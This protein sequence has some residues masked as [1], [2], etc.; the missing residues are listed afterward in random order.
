MEIPVNLV[1]NLPDDKGK[2]LVAMTT[3]ALG[4][5]WQE[6]LQE[7]LGNRITGQLSMSPYF[8]RLFAKIS[9]KEAT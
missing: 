4:D 5:D 2:A 8:H 1:I 9:I 6:C 3:G 7:I